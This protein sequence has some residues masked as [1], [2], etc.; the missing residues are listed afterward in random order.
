MLRSCFV[1]TAAL[2]DNWPLG[3]LLLEP[4]F[5]LVKALC[6]FADV[7]VNAYVFH[8]R[9]VGHAPARSK[10]HR[11]DTWCRGRW[12]WKSTAGSQVKIR[13]KAL[14]NRSPTR[15]RRRDSDPR[16]DGIVLGWC[17]YNCTP[18]RICMTYDASVRIQHSS[19]PLGIHK[20]H[21]SIYGRDVDAL[22]LWWQP[23]LTRI[24]FALI[25]AFVIERI[26]TSR[27]LISIRISRMP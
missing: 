24:T 23:R 16:V 7:Y 27:W 5:L 14:A 18:T 1:F 15:M 20:N 9:V 10:R 8:P 6:S 12:M 13:Q 26:S 21:R 3:R 4:G 25:V 2:P 22:L 17:I 19:T 11:C